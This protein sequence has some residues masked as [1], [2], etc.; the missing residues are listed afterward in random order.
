MKQVD[1]S[2][3]Y[4]INNNLSLM[5]SLDMLVANEQSSSTNFK[6]MPQLTELARQAVTL[7]NEI[8]AKF[9]SLNAKSIDMETLD[10]TKVN[11]KG[12]DA[13]AAATGSGLLQTVYMNNPVSMG[14]SGFTVVKAGAEYLSNQPGA[15][16]Q[17]LAHYAGEGSGYAAMSTN[18]ASGV[19][20]AVTSVTND[21]SGTTY[22][23]TASILGY[24]VETFIRNSILQGMANG[25]PND[26]IN[27]YQADFVRRD[28]LLLDELA[29][30]SVAGN[31]AIAGT[32]I[33]SVTE[34]P[35]FQTIL[36]IRAALQKKG[37]QR[38]D[39]HT[40]AIT[41]NEI[42]SERDAEGRFM[43]TMGKF[44]WKDVMN[45]DGTRPD[46]GLVGVVDGIRFFV[47]HGCRSTYAVTGNNITALTGGT[48]KAIF[49]GDSRMLG[50]GTGL[51]AL[52][53]TTVVANDLE[54]LRKGVVAVARQVWA[55]AAVKLPDAFGYV[56][57]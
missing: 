18:N 11:M 14:P 54:V 27:M 39:I 48:K 24:I 26:L 31:A 56:A 52:T 10:E 1:T 33:S 7:H 51:D 32:A 19:Y 45:A 57:I 37:L 53:K 5:P 17:F 2:L 34:A 29:M 46:A 50:V 40:D 23:E 38:C 22:N 30:D 42:Q 35:M 15:Q 25:N 21:K 4:L 55:G 12:L 3:L 16:L 8:V 9:P 36:N 41:M 43:T 49:V 44:V 20:S 6:N 28:G 47:N 13:G